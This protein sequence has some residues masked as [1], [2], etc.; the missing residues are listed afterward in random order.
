MK[1]HSYL[2]FQIASSLAPLLNYYLIQPN[3]RH[4]QNTV[5]LCKTRK[6]P[7]TFPGKDRRFGTWHRDI[8]GSNFC[9]LTYFQTASLNYQDAIY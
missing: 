8:Q 4:L 9:A 3:Y 6:W 1:N 5:H 7:S 2:L